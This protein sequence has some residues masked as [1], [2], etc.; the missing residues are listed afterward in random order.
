MAAG[1]LFAGLLAGCWPG[2]R[3]TLSSART[4]AFF[5]F[6]L[7]TLSRCIRIEFSELR[8]PLRS[9]FNS[10]YFNS[11]YFFWFLVITRSHE[12]FGGAPLRGN[13][14][15]RPPGAFENCRRPHTSQLEVKNWIFRTRKILKNLTTIKFLAYLVSMC[16]IL[17]PSH[18]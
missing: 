1:W 2:S 7:P 15:Y 10:R 6:F 13:E 9:N 18:G 16:L 17:E 11:R 5:E 12:R 3:P 8:A 14:S 4:F